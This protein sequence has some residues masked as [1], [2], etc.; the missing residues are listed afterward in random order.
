MTFDL[1]PHRT[2]GFAMSEKYL[3][4]PPIWPFVY[5]RVATVHPADVGRGPHL[6]AL[7]RIAAPVSF[8]RIFFSFPSFTLSHSNGVLY[9]I[10][11][12]FVRYL[13]IVVFC[14][15]LGVFWE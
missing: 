7:G 11:A 3:T 4:R 2:L 15:Y 10:R 5:H 8:G 1:C 9:N 12:L 14:M 13:R 6:A